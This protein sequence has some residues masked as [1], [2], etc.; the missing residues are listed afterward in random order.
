LIYD[1][2][3]HLKV[4]CKSR[5]DNSERA[6]IFHTTKFVIDK[7]HIRG[8]VGEVCLRECHPKLFPEL[9]DKNTVVCEQA[10]YFAGKYKYNVKHMNFVRYNFYLF[11]VFNTYNTIKIEGRI[12]ISESLNINKSVAIKRKL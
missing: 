3:C 11:I 2:A 4:F 5:A 8:H 12:P 9:D 1:D 6:R 10:N 7:L